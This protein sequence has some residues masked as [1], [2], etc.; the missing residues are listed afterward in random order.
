M[1]PG[2]GLNQIYLNRQTQT[3]R[4]AGTAG[5]R[6]AL[7]EFKEVLLNH[8]AV[9]TL[10]TPLSNFLEKVDISFVFGGQLKK[11]TYLAP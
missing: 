4:I 2:V 7:L 1:P 3:F 8:P 11:D 9:A 5:N 6:D 10:E